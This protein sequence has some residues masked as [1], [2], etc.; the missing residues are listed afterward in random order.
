MQ[1]W[2][3]STPPGARGASG[4]SRHGSRWRRMSITGTLSMTAASAFSRLPYTLRVVKGSCAPSQITGKNQQLV[5][6]CKM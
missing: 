5:Q 1:W 4:W 6:V 2:P 3:T